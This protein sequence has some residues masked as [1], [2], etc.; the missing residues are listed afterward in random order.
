MELILFEL[1]FWGYFDFGKIALYLELNRLEVEYLFN[2]GK[3]G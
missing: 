3:F 2:D 1:G